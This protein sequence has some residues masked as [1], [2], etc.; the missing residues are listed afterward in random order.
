MKLAELAVCHLDFFYFLCFFAVF[1][2]FLI[3]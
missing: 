1:S 2:T 3:V